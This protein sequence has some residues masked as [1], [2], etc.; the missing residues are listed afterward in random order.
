MTKKAELRADTGYA[1]I[2]PSGVPIAATFGLTSADAWAEGF[3]WMCIGD[4]D[5]KNKYWKRWD[6]SRRAA[7][8]RG[9]K[10]ARVFLVVE[11]R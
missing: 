1:L 5:F 2:A 3:E 7:K 9:Y 6:A 4:I 8:R 11:P 10:I